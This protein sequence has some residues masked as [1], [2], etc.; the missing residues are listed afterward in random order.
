MRRKNV[1]G[2]FAVSKASTFEGKHVLLIDDVMTTG[3]TVAAASKALRRAGAARVTVLTLARVDR[4]IPSMLS[5]T[6]SPAE[7]AVS[8]AS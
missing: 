7:F 2:A 3:S 6:S 5:P 4:R 1:A 8:G